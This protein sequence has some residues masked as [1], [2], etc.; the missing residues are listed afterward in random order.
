MSIKP[1]SKE[2]AL[3]GLSPFYQPVFQVIVEDYILPN[4]YILFVEE[5]TRH[6][7]VDDEGVSIGKMLMNE[8]DIST[9]KDVAENLS[10][11]LV[12]TNLRWI[13]V[14]LPSHRYAR[15]DRYFRSIRIGKKPSFFEKHLDGIKDLRFE[16]VFPPS[17]SF[18][19]PVKK[20][21]EQS[22]SILPLSDMSVVNRTE[23]TIDDQEST[24][25]SQ[26]HLL[27][28]FLGDVY[29]TF[30]YEKGVY[31][32]QLIQLASVSSGTIPLTN[33][34]NENQSEDIVQKLGQL[35]TMLENNLITEQEYQSKKEDLLSK[36]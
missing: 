25:E 24:T 1:I 8:Y 30:K 17:Q 20:L 33:L 31:L 18:E 36:M 2:T 13:R 22:I 34:E 26:L 14:A 7:I 27:K 12:V 6:R 21:T 11:L 28:L 4:E 10:A 29:Y 16:W 15:H 5:G 32:Y 35:K 23:F 9:H 19:I 3:H